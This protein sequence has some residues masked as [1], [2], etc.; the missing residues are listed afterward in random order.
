M[1]D[2]VIVLAIGLAILAMGGAVNSV[3]IAIDLIIIPRASS[4]PLIT[5]F[6]FRF[7]NRIDRWPRHTGCRK[8]GGLTL[9]RIARPRR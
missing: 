3:F 8:P 4:L 1:I 9:Q 7:V 5:R 2:T 6:G